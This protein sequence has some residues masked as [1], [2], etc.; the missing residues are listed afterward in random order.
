VIAVAC[1]ED[2]VVA[3]DVAEGQR[4]GAPL[5]DLSPSPMTDP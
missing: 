1:D 3:V 5:A 4:N 2:G